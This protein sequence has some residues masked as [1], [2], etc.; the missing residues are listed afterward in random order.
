MLL[1]KN[2]LISKLWILFLE[3]L[4]QG[5]LQVGEPAEWNILKVFS[6][7]RNTLIIMAHATTNPFLE[8]ENVVNLK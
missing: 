2:P 5:G 7:K 6:W 8:Q 4:A 1:E 3:A